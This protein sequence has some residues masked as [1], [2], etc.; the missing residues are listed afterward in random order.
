[1][2]K[3]LGIATATVLALMAGGAV[4]E[5]VTGTI[6]NIDLARN[7]FQIKDAGDEISGWTFTASPTNTVGAK[8][9]ELTDGD[10][11]TLE[12]T[13]GHEKQKQ[14]INVMVLKKAE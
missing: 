7:T 13:R 9:G 4:A 12:Y 6:A 11:V 3:M 10:K 1:M 14:P 5:E 8:L 2:R